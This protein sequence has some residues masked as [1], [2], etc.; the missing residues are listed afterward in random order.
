MKNILEVINLKK[1]FPKTDRGIK[2]INFSIPEG[3][4]HAFIGKME[5]E[6]QQL[7]KQ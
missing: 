5:L 2:T 3:A 6:K 7:L 4:F 1:I